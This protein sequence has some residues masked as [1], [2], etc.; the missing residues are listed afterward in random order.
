M[1]LGPGRPFPGPLRCSLE[2]IGRSSAARAAPR[3]LLGSRAA[4]S[5]S[6]DRG[7]S[8]VR[9]FVGT[10]VAVGAI[11]KHPHYVAQNYMF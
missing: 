2:H 8:A 1:S 11:D 7:A 10:G 9:V 4:G 3:Q 6:R 5:S